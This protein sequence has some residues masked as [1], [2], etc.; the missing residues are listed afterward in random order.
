MRYVMDLQ[1]AR[2]VESEEGLL[3]PLGMQVAHEYAKTWVN[4]NARNLKLER[5]YPT[6]AGLFWDLRT[7]SELA[8]EHAIEE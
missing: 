7:D 2:P 8:R 4:E 6:L 5:E 1:K 3:T